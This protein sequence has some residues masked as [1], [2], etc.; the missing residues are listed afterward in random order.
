MGHMLLYSPGFSVAIDAVNGAKARINTL[1]PAA[2]AAV[3]W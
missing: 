2:F 3:S 1:H